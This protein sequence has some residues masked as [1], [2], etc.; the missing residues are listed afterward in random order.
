MSSPHPGVPRASRTRGALIGLAVAAYLVAGLL[1]QWRL[2]RRLPS[3]APIFFDAARRAFAGGN[4]YAPFSIG[5]SFVYAPSALTFFLPFAALPARIGSIAWG[6]FGVALYGG[7]VL[8]LVRRCG[9]AI[10]GGSL[11]RL[12]TLVLAAA[13]APFL[14]T[15]S[16]GQSNSLVLFGLVVFL[17]GLEDPR[18]RWIG[19]F[20]LAVAISIKMSPV[21][22]LALPVSRADGPRLG[23]VLAGIAALAAGS[24]L[25]FPT[26]LWSEFAGIFPRMLTPYDSLLNHAPGPTLGYLLWKAGDDPS[27]G[28]LAG[29][30]FQAGALL[31][32]LAF[33][34]WKRTSP[35]LALLSS[36]SSR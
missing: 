23:R 14:E 29:S 13:Y 8:L 34:A 19:D 30:A 16:I 11:A 5:T 28:A 4:P 2:N 36:A 7:S 25:L 31:A 22:L 18:W 26:R 20:G 3:D 33:V 17:V 12:A 21:V 15:V 27:W 6:V 24:L 32:W 35:P 10:G 1:I 9:G